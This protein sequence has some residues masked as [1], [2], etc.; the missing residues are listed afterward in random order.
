L[1]KEKVM[2]QSKF[3]RTLTV[4]DENGKEQEKWV[5]LLPSDLDEKRLDSIKD[6]RIEERTDSLGNKE[7]WVKISPNLGEK[8]RITTEDGETTLEKWVE[9]HEVVEM[10]SDV[11]EVRRDEERTRSLMKHRQ[12][13]SRKTPLVDKKARFE[14]TSFIKHLTKE[15]LEMETLQKIRKEHWEKY[16]EAMDKN[17]TSLVKDY[18]KHKD[19]KNKLMKT[20]FV[21]C[22]LIGLTRGPA[23]LDKLIDRLDRAIEN[24][25]KSIDFRFKD[26]KPIFTQTF[27]RIVKADPGKQYLRKYLIDGGNG[28][29][30]NENYE[31]PPPMMKLAAQHPS[32]MKEAWYSKLPSGSSP[33]TEEQLLKELP[34]LKEMVVVP[35]DENKEIPK[36]KESKPAVVAYDIDARKF[37]NESNR[38]KLFSTVRGIWQSVDDITKFQLFVALMASNDSD[39]ITG[40]NNDW[41][42]ICNDFIQKYKNPAAFKKINY[43]EISKFSNVI[44]SDKLAICKLKLKEGKTSKSSEV[45]LIPDVASISFSDLRNMSTSRSPSFI[46]EGFSVLNDICRKNE[47]IDRYV[48]PEKY[49]GKP[50]EVK[51]GTEVIDETEI[52]TEAPIIETKTIEGIDPLTKIANAIDKVA[53][54]GIQ[55]NFNLGFEKSSDS[56]ISEIPQ[57]MKSFRDEIT[58]QNEGIQLAL[59][60]M[61]LLMKVIYE[62]VE[63][64]KS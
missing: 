4:K 25:D 46:K 9:D 36:P 28:N 12:T 18:L 8:D 48:N 42:K 37:A 7:K 43:G 11:E 23:N 19:D 58:S 1:R 32:R 62:L 41:M 2:Q 61:D 57:I 22:A 14:E 3:R 5:M 26:V 31:F 33:F 59:K 50:L 17:I 38:R 24:V 16:S 21:E 29:D 60:N 49:A 34:I 40:M 35:G 30:I 64:L 13:G 63:E 39:R 44:R 54:G 56:S 15:D 53:N 47:Q 6:L 27:K 20:Q 45:G 51:Q 55:V 10:T 52:E